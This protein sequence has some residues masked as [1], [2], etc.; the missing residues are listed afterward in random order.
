M[1]R[2]FKPRERVDVLDLITRFPLA[3][4]ASGSLHASPLPLL[5]EPGDD[6]TIAALFGHCARHNPLVRDFERNPRGL[7]LFTGPNGYISPVLVSE[8]NWAPTWNYAVLRF[9]VDIE[10]LEAETT[11]AVDRLIAAMEGDDP[12]RWSTDLL[13]A[14]RD[15]M[16][17]RIIAF[18]ARV[19]STDHHFKLGQ[20]ETEK[21]FDEIVT[22]HSDRQLTAWMQRQNEES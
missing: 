4:V 19:I 11:A 20:D 7:V 5:A 14:R 17:D 6:G 16:L 13:G 12:D 3:W 15:A 2:S 1:T 21:V 22:G 9:T 18:R 10:L 8:T